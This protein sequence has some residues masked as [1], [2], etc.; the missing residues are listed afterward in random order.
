[1]RRR[2]GNSL[3]HSVNPHCRYKPANGI[4]WD[5]IFKKQ[6]TSGEKT[7]PRFVEFWYALMGRPPYRYLLR[8]L[9]VR[10]LR[11]AKDGKTIGKT[12]WGDFGAL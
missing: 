8:D 5:T 6:N 7:H 3:R 9:L 4:H 1:M 2:L 10:K 11:E 12:F